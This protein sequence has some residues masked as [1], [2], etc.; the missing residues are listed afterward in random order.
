MYLIISD[1]LLFKINQTVPVDNNYKLLQIYQS[2]GNYRKTILIVHGHVEIPMPAYIRH[3]VKMTRTIDAF[4][5]SL[6]YSKLLQI[7]FLSFSNC[8]VEQTPQT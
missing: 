3:L 2:D 4:C 7:F 5:T 6:Y 1:S 8:T